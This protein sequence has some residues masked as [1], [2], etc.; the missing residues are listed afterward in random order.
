MVTV[1][2]FT[3]SKPFKFESLNA[4]PREYNAYKQKLQD[5]LAIID[6]TVYCDNIDIQAHAF[7]ALHRSYKIQE[8]LNKNRMEESIPAEPINHKSLELAYMASFIVID[9]EIK[10]QLF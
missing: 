8:K 10:K 9:G 6:D 3:N 5:K 7:E 1:K 4:L 2:P